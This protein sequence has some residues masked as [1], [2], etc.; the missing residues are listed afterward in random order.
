MKNNTIFIA[1]LFLLVG[2]MFF[3]NIKLTQEFNLYKDIVEAH[4]KSIDLRRQQVQDLHG[5]TYQII[6]ATG[7]NVD[8]KIEIGAY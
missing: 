6:Q 3:K 8:N 4:Q 7:I 5:I 1:I 2:F